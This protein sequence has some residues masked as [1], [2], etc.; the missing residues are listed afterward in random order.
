MVVCVRQWLCVLAAT[1]CALALAACGGQTAA[2]P[3]V[4]PTRP[5]PTTAPTVAR[6]PA[7]A[8]ASPSPSPQPTATPEPAEAADTVWVGNTDGIGVYVRKTPVIADRVRAYPD[9]T[10]LTIVGEDVDGDG[11]HWKHVRTPDGLEGYVPAIYTVESP[12]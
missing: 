11:Q 9:R 6:S 10:P 1:L 12:P 3:T 2:A 4:E 8:V 7:A 5:P